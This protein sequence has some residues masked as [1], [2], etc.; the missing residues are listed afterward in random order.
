[1]TACCNTPISKSVIS[2]EENSWV[3]Q[4]Y[5]KGSLQIKITNHNLRNFTIDINHSNESLHLDL[6]ELKIPYKTPEISWVNQDFICIKNWWSGPFQNF[7]FV[8]LRG[9]LKKHLFIQK[10]TQ[11][12]DSLVNT[13][14]Y[15]DTV[16]NN[17]QIN[18]IA[19]NLQNRKKKFIKYEIPTNA[20]FY[21][22]FDSL[23]LKNFILKFWYN[24]KCKNVSILEIK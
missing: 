7:I 20:S 9:K 6:N 13:V 3:A 11:I 21:P 24:G 18:L 12:A 17:S 23:S 4:D 2:K 14:V 5:K 1:M 22:Y 19:E 10:D 8:P 16:I 15:I